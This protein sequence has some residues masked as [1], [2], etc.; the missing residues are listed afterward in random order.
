MSVRQTTYGILFLLLCLMGDFKLMAQA[1]PTFAEILIKANK[2]YE[3]GNLTEAAD[4][5]KSCSFKKAL[6]SDRWKAHRLLAMVYLASNET[7]LAREAAE[8]ML[9]LN[10]TYKPSYLKDPAE[11]VKLL[12]NITVIPK[13]SLGL[14]LSVGTN[15]TIPVID[16]SYIVSDYRKTYNAHNSF[17]IGASI[18]YT[19]NRHLSTELGLQ[20]TR[21]AYGI[22]YEMANY[23]VEVEEKLTYIEMPLVLKYHIMPTHR[24]NYFVHGGVFGG[25]LISG[26]NNFQST[27]L[28]TNEQFEFVN[29][30]TTPRRKRLNGGIVLGGGVSYKVKDG[31]LFAY[32]NYFHSFTGIVQPDTRYRYNELV[33]DYYYIDDDITLNQFSFGIGYSFYLNYKVIKTTKPTDEN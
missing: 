14:A 18:G 25:Y 2:A 22:S 5:A 6:I 13:F 1:E 27:Y 4:L 28:P 20:A 9:E 15:T 26:F 33:Y 10:P 3:S 29:V 30:S 31:Q 23:K 19:I 8:N 32:V 12:K 16:K 7:D 21:K 24:I 11:L 17:Q